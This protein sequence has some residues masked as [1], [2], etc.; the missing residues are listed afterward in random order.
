MQPTFGSKRRAKPLTDALHF[1]LGNGSVAGS[2]FFFTSPQMRMMPG[3]SLVSAC[4]R[5][6]NQGDALAVAFQA[7]EGSDMA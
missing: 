7:A 3:L 2:Y 6:L 4:L 1:S 5:I